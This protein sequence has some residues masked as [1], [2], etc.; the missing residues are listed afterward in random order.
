MPDL[1]ED[2][3]TGWYILI[4]GQSNHEGTILNK[5]KT[6]ARATVPQPQEAYR[7]NTGRKKTTLQT[8]VT[9]AYT[10]LDYISIN[11]ILQKLNSFQKYKSNSPAGYIP[12]N[13]P[14]LIT[15]S[16]LNRDAK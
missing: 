1:L 2:Q 7:K 3:I 6:T 14:I 5:N 9:A 10:N 13:Q 4:D 8:K 16:F 11:T 15:K 12:I